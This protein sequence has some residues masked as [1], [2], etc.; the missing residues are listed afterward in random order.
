MGDVTIGT[1]NLV[2]FSDKENSRTWSLDDHTVQQPEIVIQKR[3]VPQGLN[4]TE[5]SSSILKV[6]IGT[7]D[8]AALPMQ[9]KVTFEVE[10]R[11]PVDAL[12]ADITDAQDIFKALVAS[13][14]FDEMV[15]TQNYLG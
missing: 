13:D 15:S 10:V 2:E 11:Y 8:S 3:K 1:N 7:V 9:Q 4:P 5:I 12:A 14:E 6:V